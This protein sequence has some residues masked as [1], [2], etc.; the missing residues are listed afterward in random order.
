MDRIGGLDLAKTFAVLLL[1]PVHGFLGYY[2][3]AA[4]Y[5]AYLVL[6]IF[7]YSAGLLST[8]SLEAK[9]PEAF[10]VGKA[11]TVYVPY[12]LAA[13]FY[14][15]VNL[16]PVFG[17]SNVTMN[18]AGLNVLAA[19]AGL[20]FHL[21]FVPALLVYLVALALFHRNPENL[22]FLS[23][24]LFLQPWVDSRVAVYFPVFLAGAYSSK[25]KP[26]N[27]VMAGAAL[28]LGAY[29]SPAPLDH[30]FWRALTVTLLT[31]PA[32]HLFNQVTVRVPIAETVAKA[33]LII[34]LLEPLT[35]WLVAS[36]LGYGHDYTSVPPPLGVASAALRI[37]VTVG[38]GVAISK[39]VGRLRLASPPS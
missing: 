10:L 22:A 18:L 20:S 12:A 31:V 32:M 25:V 8:R 2:P 6:G 19:N 21:W 9:T 35:G 30:V 13:V 33:T 36:P 4:T 39:G 5:M 17:G 11:K 15:L 34:Y 16:P 23:F 7:F 27:M 14:G 26:V 3:P 1:F 37:V 29:Y 38:L 24:A 28:M